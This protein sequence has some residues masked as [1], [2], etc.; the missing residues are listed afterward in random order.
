MYILSHPFF[1]ATIFSKPWPVTFVPT[2]QSDLGKIQNRG[3]NIA[4]LHLT[5]TSGIIRDKRYHSWTTGW[6]CFFFSSFK[7]AVGKIPIEYQ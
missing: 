5:H 3:N 1:E 4:N 7:K 2:L 6:L